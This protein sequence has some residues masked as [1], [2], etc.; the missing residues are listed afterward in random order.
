MGKKN[1]NKEITIGET[2]FTLQ[3]PGIKWSLDHDYNCRDRNGQLKTSDFVQGFLEN[4]VINPKGFKIDDFES[5]E[6]VMEFQ[7]KIRDFL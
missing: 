1:D 7:N 3:H 6:Q 4:I 5:L 2:T